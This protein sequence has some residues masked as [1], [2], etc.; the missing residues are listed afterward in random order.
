[1]QIVLYEKRKKERKK[2]RIYTNGRK[3]KW[4]QNL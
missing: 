1:M 2:E 4:G 3:Q